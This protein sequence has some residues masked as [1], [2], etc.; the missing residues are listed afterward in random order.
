MAIAEIAPQVDETINELLAGTDKQEALAQL[1]LA[2]WRNQYDIR[3]LWACATLLKFFEPYLAYH[4]DALWRI[5]CGTV[6]AREVGSE[7]LRDKIL[8]DE[9]GPSYL[10]VVNA[11]AQKCGFPPK[12]RATNPRKRLLFVS[13]CLISSDHSPTHVALEYTSALARL[14]DVEIMLLDARHYPDERLSDFAGAQW[15]HSRRPS[16]LASLD[17]GGR[18]VLAYTTKAQ[19][20]NEAKI[21][22]AMEVALGFNPDFV[23]SHGW[24]NLIGDLLA[25]QFPTICMEMTRAEPVSEAH[26]FVLFENMVKS[27]RMPAT[28]L[29]P[30]VPKIYSMS[31]H[32]PVPPK[33][34]TY[35]RQRLGLAED[36]IVYAIVGYRLVSEISDEFEDVLAQILEAVPNAVILTAGGLHRYHHPFL[37]HEAQRIRHLGVE[38]DLRA[39]FAI[40]D[41]YLNPPRQG[42]GTTALLALSEHLP[43]VT[44]PNCDTAGVIGNTNAVPD[45]DRFAARAIALGR[46][47]EAR[48]AARAMARQLS[49]SAPDFDDIVRALWD[50]LI[51]TKMDFDI[52]L[53]T[54]PG[55]QASA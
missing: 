24:F 54:T 49:D 7:P 28:G 6:L 43:I 53:A 42:G 3:Y 33:A 35:T 2:F 11:L 23:I 13:H 8:Y 21:V 45:L 27:L 34:T 32:L 12:V 31:S 52:R 29:L 38:S 39:L 26:S 10:R 14:F 15:M 41:C 4:H 25:Q 50:V 20:M 17:L 36:D 46:D 44:L 51:E 55:S 47:S 19:G 48:A 30:H 18:S 37:Q 40:C 5:L 9:L 1:S 22:E 16:G